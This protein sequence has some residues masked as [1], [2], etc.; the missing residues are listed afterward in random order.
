M[1]DPPADGL[2]VRRNFLP[3]AQLARLLGALDRLAGSWASS[4]ALG[5]LGRGGTHQIRATAVAA[6]APMGEVRELLAPAALKWAQACG[7]RFAAPPH[8]QIF[9]VRMVGDAAAPPHQEPHIDSSPALPGSPA[10]TNVFYATARAIQ[11]GDLALAGEAGVDDPIIVR[12][13]PNTLVSFAGDRVH[14]V[15][16]LLAGERV[17]V[18]INFY[19]A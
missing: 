7:F 8:L 12:P 10:C 13:T 14:W 2:H 4:E 18:V 3:P 5:L 6:Q 16:P 9:P 19:A 17:S 1:A 15:L 11:G